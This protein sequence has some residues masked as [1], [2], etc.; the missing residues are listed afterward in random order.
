M[1]LWVIV[2]VKPLPLGKSRLASV[3]SDEERVVLNRCLLVH[4]LE[5]LKRSAGIERVLVVSRDPQALS[6]ARD[7]GAHTVLEH[8]AP[9]LNVALTRATLIAKTQARRGVLILPADLALLTPDEVAALLERNQ[10]PPVVVIAPDR[11]QQGTNALLVNPPGL[12]QYCYGPGS[13]ARHCERARQAG[14]RLEIVNLPALGLDVDLPE[15]LELV[16][17]EVDDMIYWREEQ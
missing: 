3:L 9:Q 1:S 11:R 8:G 5:T 16:R 17:Q 12:L 6:L 4:T 13:F 15:D 10:G 7:Y 2:P 14:A